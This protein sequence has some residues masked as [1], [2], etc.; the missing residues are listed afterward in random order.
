M[1][2]ASNLTSKQAR[3]CRE[4]ASGKS[5]AE[6]Y[7]IAYDVHPDASPKT[8]IEAA[9]RLM[10][11]DNI[12]A[13]YEALVAARERGLQA[14]RLSQTDLVLAR[15]R[16]AVDDPED[17]GSFGPNRLKAIQIL[18]Q[19]SGLM[20]NDIHLTQEDSRSSETI[21][22]DLD[23]KLVALGITPESAAES[24]LESITEDIDADSDE[25]ETGNGGAVH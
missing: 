20:R 19:V 11:R 9:S 16:E 1:A 13:R 23:A 21:L 15:L 7:R 4:L 10:A 17:G 12:R 2:K 6:A 3:F 22:S 25:L 14:K 8:Q 5:Q 24:G 18:A